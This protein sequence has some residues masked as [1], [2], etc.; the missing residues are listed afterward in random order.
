MKKILFTFALLALALPLT[1]RAGVPE[2]ASYLKTQTQDDW[3]TQALVA[4]GES[5]DASSLQSFSGSSATDYAKRILALAAAGESPYTFTGT[6]LVLGLKGLVSAGQLGDP[7]LVNDDA[8]GIIA[9]RAA[10]VSASDVVV[11]GAKSFLLA[12]QNSDGG[13]AWA[14]GFDSD[15]NDTAA[16]L[17]ALGEL[18]YTPS[19]SVVA[20]AL[21]Y[22]ATQQGADGGFSYQLPCFWPGCEASDAASTS[23][24]MSALY[25]LKLDP[26]S[27]TKGAATPLTFL[28]SL[29]TGD[30]SFKWQASD[31]AGSA[32]MTAYAVVALAQKF[33]PVKRY[34]GGG[35][36]W[37]SIPTPLADLKLTV[38][39][40]APQDSGVLAYTIT[41]E[42]LGPNVA[43]EISVI[44]VVPT[45]FNLVLVSSSDGE[46]LAD[47]DTWVLPRLNNYASATLTLSV[48]PAEGKEPGVTTRDI[49]VHSRELDNNEINNAA[50]VVL[51]V[52]APVA[53]PAPQV[54]GVETVSCSDLVAP[55]P[56]NTFGG[57]VALADTPNLVWYWDVA[58]GTSDCLSTD[59]SVRALFE[60]RA[61]GITNA[62][63]AALT[64]ESPLAARLKG[65]LLL[66]T[67]SLGE[68]WY[69]GADGSLTYLPP[70]LKSIGILQGLLTGL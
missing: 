42:N 16:V 14:V 34:S 54:L 15:T 20:N 7:T 69:V 58:S 50:S 13:W 32:G 38:G 47:S 61:L 66:Q 60:S 23:W 2:A 29:Q 65:R 28:S 1:V 41:L 48:R 67:E 8:W 57:F 49:R 68:V 64:P 70:D 59:S 33:Y 5:M 62:N 25:K 22:L 63:L 17:M 11:A 3:V 6:D 30:G 12:H 35:V 53:E 4:A 19:D 24:V 9:L 44:D 51:Q 45:G 18:G 52:K 26:A 31:P 40:A 46:H 43:T 36:G 21:A 56:L 39:E 37:T 27:Y 55:A 10:G